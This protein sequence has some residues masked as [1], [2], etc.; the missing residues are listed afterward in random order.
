MLHRA[1]VVPVAIA[2][3]VFALILGAA[4]L[5]R[6]RDEVRPSHPSRAAT[7]A[8]AARR[9]RLPFIANAGQ[10][11][12]QVAFVAPS[13]GAELYVT[14][15]GALVHS[16]WRAT[17]A[18][19]RQG[20][21]LTEHLRSGAATPSG[22]E[23]AL[24]QVSAFLGADPAG[25]RSGVAT[26][27]SVRLGEV[28]P[29]V[30]VELRARPDGLEK[31][32]TVGPGA[33]PGAIGVRLDG[34]LGL[35]V[36]GSGALRVRTGLGE[37]SFS[38]P[39]AW[40]EAG[41]RRVPVAVAYAPRAD[42]YGFA[43]GAYDAS[44]A[45][46]IDPLLDATFLGGVYSDTVLA[47][48][49]SATTGDVYVVGPTQSASFPGTAGGAQPTHGSASTLRHDGFV[50]RL[51][52]SLGLVQATF[53]GGEQED[54]ALAVAVDAASGD[55]FVTGYTRSTNFPGTAGGAFPVI[56]PDRWDAFVSR[57][58]GELTALKQSTFLG[59]S[60]ED[61]GAALALDPASGEPY[62]LGWTLSTNFPG[63]AGGAQATNTG[64]GFRWDAFVAHL[65]KD[66]KTLV[67]ATYLGGG[68]N[69][70]PEA[71]ALTGADVYLTGWTDSANFPG[72]AGGAQVAAGGGMYDGF[73]ARLSA[74]L[75]T[76]RQASYLGGTGD[77]Y[78]LGLAVHPTS[79]EVWVVGNTGSYDFPGTAGGAQPAHVPDG[80]RDVIVAQ[81]DAALTH[82][83]H[84]TYLGGAGDDWG[85]GVALNAAAGEL[86][87][88]GAT[89]SAAFPGTSGGVQPALAGKSDV[90][91][92]RLTSDLGALRQ[93]TYLGGSG[94][95]SA[96]LVERTATGDLLVAGYTGSYD[97]PATADAG[98]P[99][100]G[101]GAG[102]GF[103]ARLDG[104]LRLEVGPTDS[105]DLSLA[106][107]DAPDPVV[108][109]QALTW[110]LTV[111]NAGP[112][113][114]AQVRV[115]DAL[116]AGL[117]RLSVTP[118][119]GSCPGEGPL[120]CALGTVPAGGQ[121]TVTVV[122]RPTAAGT[123]VNTATVSSDTADPNPANDTAT[124]E[125]TVQPLAAAADLSL[126]MATAT[127][128]VEAGAEV[129][130]TLA[131]A[132]AGPATALAAA[133]TD[134]LPAGATFVS[135]S[136]TRGDCAPAEGVVTCALG[137]LA[138]AATVT[139]QVVLVPGRAGE[140]ENVA[141]VSST[142]ADPVLA[143]N[144]ARASV[145]VLEVTPPGGCGCSCGAGLGGEVLAALGATL[146]VRRQ[147]PPRSSSGA[148]LD[149]APRPVTGDKR[150]GCEGTVVPA[151]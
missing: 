30:T 18:G 93:S 56:S 29:G 80:G 50:A 136:S 122:V 110:T 140:H 77:D 35:E 123:L 101:G 38:P 97:F 2:A 51:T 99:T 17:P 108:V 69:D 36:T 58:N 128:T 130:F 104:T 105:A 6:A 71:L 44:R 113:P 41:S 81:L 138:P 74:S 149:G 10:L 20:W 65:S 21:T 132:N 125:T 141:N 14:R 78:L 16:L 15:D 43:L 62:V 8:E 54:Q 66:L 126:T 146:L 131:A 147:R 142:T 114:A 57:L 24:A 67:Q 96:R 40:Q 73:V 144:E 26:W 139:V 150:D 121:A 4:G 109:G 70:F 134:T 55:V 143:N 34:A 28:W 31:R 76:L 84:G 90:F 151:G 79:G 32:F 127:P 148:S 27:D 39:V 120:S 102:D 42:G 95:D 3:F 116:P 106:K 115:M 129:T 64:E 33:D 13:P 88:A 46:V 89:D 85:R 9:L 92:A 11:D 25:W 22:G 145:T 68:G 107:A 48:A 37:V 59:G 112:Q 103:V 94:D 1:R 7:P 98:Q 91:L 87:L 61:D 72:T 135:A 118:S 60:D 119:Q 53:L 75:T 133:L 137:D 52:P 23:R 19:E 45:V 63:T 49:R 100:F 86:V 111:A 12:P 124:S 47:L 117:D 82:L 83:Q 5:L